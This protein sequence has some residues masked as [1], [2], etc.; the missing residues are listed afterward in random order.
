MKTSLELFSF[1]I[2]LP[3]SAAFFFFF[4]NAPERSFCGKLLQIAD[5]HFLADATRDTFCAKRTLT[6]TE[7]NASGTCP[8]AS[9][10]HPITAPHPR[11]TFPSPVPLLV[12][13][14]AIINPAIDSVIDPAT[15]IR[16]GS[17]TY[18]WNENGYNL[19]R[20][21]RDDF[22]RWFTNEQE[23]RGIEIQISKVRARSP[24]VHAQFPNAPDAHARSPIA[25]ARYVQSL[26]FPAPSSPSVSANVFSF[27]GGR[28]F[29]SPILSCIQIFDLHLLLPNVA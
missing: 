17:I 10:Q 20:E 5:F 12:D 24:D 22:D 14:G 23:A 29:G 8:H 27:S 16:M 9:S 15:S 28:F 1:L 21:S 11:M 25:R 26:S 7:G 19:E 18:G 4:S 13:A 6:C 3:H 2:G